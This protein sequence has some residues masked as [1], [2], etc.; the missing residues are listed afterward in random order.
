MQSILCNPMAYIQSYTVENI[1]VIFGGL[2][3]IG[4]YDSDFVYYSAEIPGTTFISYLENYE[5]LRTTTKSYLKPVLPSNES[6]TKNSAIKNI[7]DSYTCAL[8]FT[9]QLRQSF[10]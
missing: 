7:I 10:R 3:Y 4:N 1:R 8:H 6:C 2:Q 5:R 9:F